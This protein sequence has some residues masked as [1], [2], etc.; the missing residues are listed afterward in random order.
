MLA[1]IVNILFPSLVLQ[2]NVTVFDVSPCFPVESKDT[3]MFP[4]LP[5]LIGVLGYSGTV[6]PQEPLAEVIV[7]SAS[8]VFLNLKS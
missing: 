2:N 6:Q 8:P 7:K 5:T 1:L 4:V 3:F